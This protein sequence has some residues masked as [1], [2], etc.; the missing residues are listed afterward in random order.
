MDMEG[1]SETSLNINLPSVVF[2]PDQSEYQG[3]STS[4]YVKN[5]SYQ[6]ITR[7]QGVVGHDETTSTLVGMSSATIDIECHRKVAVS[8]LANNK[9]KNLELIDNAFYAGSNIIVSDKY[10]PSRGEPVP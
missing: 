8:Y 10:A 3:L 4:H 7:L 9:V 5:V 1:G 6:I 2:N